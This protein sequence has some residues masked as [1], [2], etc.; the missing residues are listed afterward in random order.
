MKLRRVL[1]TI[2]KHFQQPAEEVLAVNFIDKFLDNMELCEDE[3]SEEAGSNGFLQTMVK[4]LFAGCGSLKQY[5]KLL[6][7]R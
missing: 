7:G 1:R 2:R 6:R 3:L 4:I 5:K